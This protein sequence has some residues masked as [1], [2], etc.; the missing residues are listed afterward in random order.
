MILFIRHSLFD[1]IF[2]NLIL[3]SC[4][5]HAVC[6]RTYV[7]S[8][9]GGTG[10]S[11]TGADN[12]AGVSTALKNPSGVWQDTSGI[13]YIS[14]TGNHVIRYLD[15]SNIMHIY[16]GT[17]GVPGYTG[18]NGPP[19]SGTLNS[20]AGI[21]GVTYGTFALVIADQGNHVLR[22]IYQGSITTAAGTGVAGSVDGN[23]ATVPYAQYNSPSTCRIDK[24]GNVLVAEAGSNKIRLYTAGTYYTTTLIGTGAS[25]SVDDV[26]LSATMA[27]PYGVYG[28]TTGNV[29]FVDTN[30]H[31]IRFLAS[32]GGSTTVQV[33]TGVNG[34]LDYC[35][36]LA[37]Q[38]SFPKGM[39][40][41]SL[42][43]LF[44]AD[45]GNDRIRVVDTA[46][47]WFIFAVFLLDVVFC[48]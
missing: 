47:S 44:F 24:N 40:S 3:I 9:V 38:V 48:F 17:A 7:I 34:F 8:T 13:L 11:G 42:G 43:N 18:D 12:L 16:A 28:D 20:P 25:G 2:F 27:S 37:A 46:G 30:S 5:H 23:R 19:L 1:F 6:F 41:D 29:Y 26:A 14:D 10:S 36:S 33:G 4:L 21:C 35:N 32:T 31:K 39:W 45:S 22:A 15:T